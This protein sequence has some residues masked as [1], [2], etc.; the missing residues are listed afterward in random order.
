MAKIDFIPDIQSIEDY[1]GNIDLNNRPKVYNSDGSYSTEKSFSVNIDGK[2]VLLPTIINGHEVSE[3]DA[4]KHYQQTGEHLGIF[5]TPQEADI[6]AE[7]I[8]NRFNKID[9]QPIDFQEDISKKP[10]KSFVP[11]YA[12]VEEL[13]ASRRNPI[14]ALIEESAKKPEPFKH[15]LSTIMQPFVFGLKGLDALRYL[16]FSPISSAGLA[17]QRGELFTPQAGEEILKSF[18][19][20]RFAVPADI[21]KAAGWY[22]A[23]ADLAGFGAELGLLSPKSTATTAKRMVTEPAT[24]AREAGQEIATIGRVITKP[25]KEAVET[26][27]NIPNRFFRGGLTKSEAIRV[28]SQYGASNGTLLEQAKNTLDD[29]TT[30]VD[31]TYNAVFKKA[32]ENKFIDIKPSINEAGKRLKRLNLI[33]EKGN[34]TEL[35]QSE[36]AK[37]SVYGKLLDFYQSSKAISGVEKLEGRALTQSQMLRAFGAE[38]QTLVNKDQYLFFRD[39]LNSLYKNK[40]SDIDVSR[41]VDKFYQAGEDSGLKGLQAARKLER[42]AFYYK[43]KFLNENGD[44]KLINEAKLNKVGIGKLAQQDINHIQELQQYVKMPILDDAGKI[45]KLNAAKQTI[46]NIKKYGK[47]SA[48]GAVAGE[49]G[50]KIVT[51]SW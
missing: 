48:G 29:I 39:K 1:T 40:P 12:E 8:H 20:E 10:T 25:I 14:Q 13:I 44:F 22:P 41:V 32:P 37:D 11:K 28:E 30:Q 47:Y 31:N 19:G 45:N 7:K 27:K 33:T 16:A 51:G 38:R 35:G 9:F 23:L 4:I 50:R 15:P 6:M 49:V 3:T 43:G 17:A 5:N 36:I 18:T 34:L 42:K 46:K 21:G 26:I 24:V 2:E